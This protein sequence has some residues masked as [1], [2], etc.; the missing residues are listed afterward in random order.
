MLSIENISKS[1]SNVSLR[2]LFSGINENKK[3]L[4][5]IS[6]KVDEGEILMLQGKNGSGKTTLLK[7][8]SGLLEQDS[9]DINLNNAEINNNE[10]A[11]ISNNERSFFWRL[12]IL[13]NLRFF[14]GINN[15]SK[16]NESID[17]L[18]A[19]F[20]LE[21]IKNKRFMHLSSGEKQRVNIC[22]GLLR[23][24]KVLLL[25]EVSSSL[26][27]T[28]KNLFFTKIRDILVSKPNLILIYVSHNTD[29][30]ELLSPTR[31]INLNSINK[32]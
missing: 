32:E 15:Y 25:D 28:S 19:Y 10:V 1:F 2:S 11:L 16:E 18:L 4:S 23:D 22:R 26:D 31:I 20:E 8:I 21:T 30:L 12:T 5:N 27:I 6:F 7:I 17:D 24:Y 13:E 14:Q 9:G 3:V 29:E